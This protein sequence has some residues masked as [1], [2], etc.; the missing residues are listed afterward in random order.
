MKIIVIGIRGIP[1]IQGGVE[2]HSEELYP[3][4]VRK[5]CEVTVL[6]R[7]CYVTEE[8]RISSYKDVKLHDLY[9]PRT[10]SFEA[11][12]HTFLG[13]CYARRVGADLVHCHAIGPSIVIPFAR[14]LGLKV[15]M[16]HHGPDYERKKWS[17]LARRILRQGERWGVKYANKVIV[18]SQVIN[19]LITTKY[20]RTD[21]HL[22]YNGTPRP[23][24]NTSTN[25]IDQFHLEPQKYI[26]A[27]GRFVPEKGFDGLIEAYTRSQLRKC[28]IRLVLAGDADHEDEYSRRLKQQA[29]D[30][31]VILTGFIRGAQLNQ[32]MTHAGLFVLPSFHEGLPIS[33]LE[34]MSYGLPVLVS[35]IPANKEVGLPSTDYFPCGDW[36]ALETNLQMKFQKGDAAVEYDL[37]KY[38]WDY[39]TDQVYEVYKEVV[40]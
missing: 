10:K 30:H 18:I 24:K 28:G 17:P 9:A 1:L 16:T 37:S 32:L 38:D 26:V 21:G 8:N 34:A 25:C 40:Q 11:I 15:V 5:G 19:Q 39:I 31:G 35:D 3:R 22:I 13:I 29:R 27:L 14:L 20:H 33:L 23:E 36:N 2:T 6:R 4:L 7:S 12:I